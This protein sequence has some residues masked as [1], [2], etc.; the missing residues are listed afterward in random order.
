MEGAKRAN[1]ASDDG[2]VQ[3]AAPVFHMS[4][5]GEW[6]TY[7][8]PREIGREVVGRWSILG[9]ENTIAVVCIVVESG[10]PLGRKASQVA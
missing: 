4:D 2:C 3:H 9:D 10:V 8:Q 5:G 6:S 7:K 1:D